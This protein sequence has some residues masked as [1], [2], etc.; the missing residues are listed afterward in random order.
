MLSIVVSL[1]AGSV[2]AADAEL[3]LRE[4]VIDHPDSDA[5]LYF[6]MGLAHGDFDADGFDEIAV[7]EPGNNT[8]FVY[9]GSAR[10]A[11]TTPDQAIRPTT[12]EVP[13]G[14][15]GGVF[16]NGVAAFDGN[17]DGYADLAVG[18]STFIPSYV[19]LYDGGPGGLAPGS[20]LAIREPE[21]YSAAHFGQELSSAGD[22]NG[23]GFEDLVVADDYWWSDDPGTHYHNGALFVYN[24]GPSGVDTCPELLRNPDPKLAFGFMGERV[25]S[26]GDV[27]GD[28]YSD[29]VT[30]CYRCGDDGSSQLVFWLGAADAPRGPFSVK[31]DACCNVAMLGDVDA[32]GYDDLAGVNGGGAFIIYGSP[33]GP[34]V[35][36]PQTIPDFRSDAAGA[37]DLDA[38]GYADMILGDEFDHSVGVVFGGPDRDDNPPFVLLPQSEN[39]DN[40]GH[41]VFG[42]LD[43]NGD[44]RPEA[45]AADCY[46][47]GLQGSVTVFSPTCTWYA[48]E[49]GD[50]AGD[51]AVSTSTCHDP[52]A[53]WAARPDD[54]DDGDPAVQ[55]SVWYPDL[56]GDGYGTTPDGSLAC[57]AS[58]SEVAVGRDCDDSDATRNPDAED[59]AADGVDQ[60]CDGHDGPW[61]FDTGDCPDTGDT[62]DTADSGDS[63]ETGDSG[64]ADT[65]P[66]D[67]ADTATIDTADTSPANDD[68]GHG[69]PRDP[70]CG[71]NTPASP[72]APAAGALLAL[73]AA[74]ATRR[75]A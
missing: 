60:D 52:G 15:F 65:G 37:G 57:A 19:V 32:D 29:L 4:T 14:A 6:G 16:G 40:W 75:R 8:V 59:A 36:H 42:G 17:G 47:D 22:T 64:P 45:I 31:G 62:G 41:D 33:A 43:V 48:D 39:P 58:P 68:T 67:T 3:A 12:I 28:G 70:G 24:G 7:G 54:C 23:D 9:A 26:N 71:C 27:D 13:D 55:G 73:A 11:A 18:V 74:F 53:G 38:D 61:T 2:Q 69:S 46:A 20:E 34:D 56:D 66:L 1:R 35:D 44:G 49:D 51:P 21:A 30:D 5:Y 25:A 63:A 72:G 50:G 10:G